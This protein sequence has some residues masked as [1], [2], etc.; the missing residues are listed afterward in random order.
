[1]E[2]LE[3]YVFTAI[4]DQDVAELNTGD[5][6]VPVKKIEALGYLEVQAS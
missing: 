6:L 3:T 5:L 1:V 2:A 4:K